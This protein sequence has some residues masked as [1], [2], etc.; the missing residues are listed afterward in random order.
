MKY[1][2]RN[3]TRNTVLGDAIDIADTSEKRTTGLLKHTEL[4]PGEGLWIVP[5]EGVHTFFMRFPLDLVFIDRKHV[6]RKTV[7]NVP[8][9]RISLCLPAHSI[10]E[11]P[12]GTIQS[13]GTQKGDQLA[14][15][16]ASQ[17]PA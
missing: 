15:E 8:P 11:L 7:G 2:A 4:R 5:C 12:V 1:R 14:F 17:T 6:V 16:S 13:A 3:L 10:L 9:W